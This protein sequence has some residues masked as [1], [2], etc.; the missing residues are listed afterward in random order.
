M[1]HLNDLLLGYVGPCW[2][3]YAAKT[4]AIKTD[5]I[6]IATISSIKVNPLLDFDMAFIMQLSFFIKVLKLKT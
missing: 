6:A 5:V 1:L 3:M 4:A 2:V